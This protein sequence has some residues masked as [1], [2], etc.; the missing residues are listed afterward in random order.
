MEPWDPTRLA[1]AFPGAPSCAC[2]VL[3]GWQ[4][5]DSIRQLYLECEKV[6][7]LPFSSQAIVLS[8]LFDILSSSCPHISA[9]CIITDHDRSSKTSLGS[10]LFYQT[11]D[12]P[13][14]AFSLLGNAGLSFA[15]TSSLSYPTGL[16]LPISAVSKKRKRSRRRP[17]PR[18]PHVLIAWVHGHLG[19]KSRKGS[20]PVKLGPVHPRKVHLE[21]QGSFLRGL[22]F[23]DVRCLLSELQALVDIIS[24]L[25]LTGQPLPFH[26]LS[27]SL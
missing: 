20:I 7:E 14:F 11:P 16:V 6:Q 12:L 24:W 3:D 9:S 2:W 25:S 21:N 8:K 10:P 26:F 22:V 13:K 5:H 27:S 17:L 18:H 15:P 4:R 1:G 19:A 23:I